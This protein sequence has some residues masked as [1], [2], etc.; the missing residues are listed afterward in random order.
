MRLP[1]LFKQKKNKTYGYT[2][3]YYNERKERIDELKK[4]YE[5]KEGDYD[6]G[7]RRENY[8]DEWKKN[9]NSSPEASTRLRFIIILIFLFLFAYVA[10]RYVNFDKLF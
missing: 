3:R 7:Y 8:R 1:S 5:V 2:P 9:R 4:K 10:L 6:N